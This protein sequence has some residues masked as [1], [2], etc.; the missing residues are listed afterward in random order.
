MASYGEKQL[1]KTRFWKHVWELDAESLRELLDEGN[2]IGHVNFKFRVPSD[3]GYPLIDSK[4]YLTETHQEQHHNDSLEKHYKM[5][6][7]AVKRTNVARQFYLESSGMTADEIVRKLI[8]SFEPWRYRKIYIEYRDDLKFIK[9]TLPNGSSFHIEHTHR[10]LKV[11]WDYK[12]SEVHDHCSELGCIFGT[13]L[14]LGHVSIKDIETWQRWDTEDRRKLLRHYPEQFYK[15]FQLNASFADGGPLGGRLEYGED[16]EVKQRLWKMRLVKLDPQ[17]WNLKFIKDPPNRTVSVE[18]LDDVS[19]EELQA[20][21]EGH[22]KNVNV[23]DVELALSDRPAKKA[24]SLQIL[25]Y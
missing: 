18:G 24:K 7:T 2:P 6:E 13:L 19:V 12:T 4:F 25:I 15:K 3:H 8:Y 21:Y 14:G 23:H 9:P 11:L 16:Y 1:F 10:I 5:L 22:P 20:M 17:R